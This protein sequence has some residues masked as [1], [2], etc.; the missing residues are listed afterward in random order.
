MTI[1]VASCSGFL[2]DRL[3]GAQELVTGG[4]IDF[5]TGDWLAELT[6]SILT[7][8]QH[9]DPDRGYPKTFLRQMS[10]IL[11]TCK[12]RGIRVI[13]NAGGVNPH[14]CADA[15]AEVAHDLGIDVSIAVVDGDDITEP[16]TRWV[17]D[18]GWPGAHIESGASFDSL[19]VDPTVVSAYLGSWGITEALDAGADVVITG[20]V[21]DASPIVAAAAHSYGWGRDDL[22]R[23]AGAVAAGHVIECSAQATGGNFSFFQEVAAPVHPGFPIAE[24]DEDGSAV[25]TKHDGTNGTVTTETVISQLLYEIDGPSYVN[26]DVVARFDT[27]TVTQLDT[28]RVRISGAVGTSVPDSYKVGAVCE[29]GWNSEMSVLVTGLDRDAKV[30][31]LLAQVWNEFPD[32]KDTFEDVVIDVIGGIPGD[33]DADGAGPNPDDA[34]ALL[35]VAV[36]SDDRDQVNRFPR[37][38]VEQLMGGFPG[39]AMPTP[40]GRAKE[41]QRFWPTLVPADRVP[42]RVTFDGRTWEVPHQNV[43][44]RP[45][46]A[47]TD[48]GTPVTPDPA[49]AGSTSGTD[50]SKVRVPVGRIAGARSGD[51]GGNS[52]LGL[53]ARNDESYRFLRNWWSREKIADLLGVGRETELRPWEMPNVRAVGVTV[54]GWLGEGAATNMRL[55]PHGKGLGEFV[56]A[57]A[58]DV[59]ET[60]FS[61]S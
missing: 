29:A 3:A 9:R 40:P 30:D 60:L 56:R 20:R 6:M 52:T 23:I 21:S 41:R 19:G 16:F 43:A 45:E 51:K 26:P 11:T 46:S 12:S 39:M 50:T 55:D 1:R 58:I 59:P 54:V 22:D 42:Q 28:D 5:L 25:I 2:G 44:P 53:W 4:P 17:S 27:L 49:P 61:G 37:V 10:G 34:R 36:A 18:E 7:K 57:R 24:I 33:G 47:D 35:R 32:G 31:H 15:V 8:Q 38:V 13:A 14:G 48:A